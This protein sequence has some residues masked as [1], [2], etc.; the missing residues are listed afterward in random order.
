MALYRF[1]VAFILIASLVACGG[2]VSKD[3]SAT[4]T[5]VFLDSPV[6][7]L[8]YKTETLSGVTNEYGEFSYIDGEKVSFYLGDAFLGETLASHFITPTN[9]LSDDGD[10]SANKVRNLIRLL[11]SFDDDRKPENGIH[12]VFSDEN[13]IPAGLINFDQSIE[14]FGAD[15]IVLEI[16][17]HNGFGSTLISDGTAFLHFQN[18]LKES[19]LISATE[20]LFYISGSIS[21]LQGSIELSNYGIDFITVS[22]GDRFVFPLSVV[23]GTPYNISIKNH[24]VGQSC[25]LINNSG[26]V[27]GVDIT[28][29]AVICDV[30]RTLIT[31]NVMGLNGSLIIKADSQ[32]IL[33]SDNGVFTTGLSKIPDLVEIQQNP[34]NQTCIANILN[35]S[36]DIECTGDIFSLGGTVTGLTGELTLLDSISG[37]SIAVNGDFRFPI[38]FKE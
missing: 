8:V 31:G 33:I 37:Q 2:G 25:K 34:E 19:N 12:I 1:I 11:Q 15:P 21:G 30:D 23:N 24:P 13:K 29:I 20:E 32:T 16:L 28:S 6:Q 36:I 18:T 22:E 3:K 5:G 4:L 35:N 9:L 7:G 38:L 17:K 27:S 10:I 26:E 14:S